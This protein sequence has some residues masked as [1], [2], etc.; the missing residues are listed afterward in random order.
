MHTVPNRRQ[1][2]PEMLQGKGSRFTGTKS[3]VPEYDPTRPVP[4]APR[5]LRKVARDEWKSFFASPLSSLVNLDTDMDAL[6]DWAL[7]V[8]ERER[9]REEYTKTPLTIGASGSLIENPLGRVIARYTNQINRYRDQFGMTPLSRMRLGIAVGQAA[10][11]LDSLNT[12]RDDE[13]ETIEVDDEPGV[14]EAQAVAR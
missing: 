10:E 2:P 3:I 9:L 14:I 5:G 1:K 4:L 8:S 7:L 6:R 11:V 12:T 13:V